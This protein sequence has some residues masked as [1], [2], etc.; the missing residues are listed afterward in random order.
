MLS[1][2]GNPVEITFPDQSDISTIPTAIE[3]AD[4]P[5]IPAMS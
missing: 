5:E 3:P 4:Q 1:Q 2:K